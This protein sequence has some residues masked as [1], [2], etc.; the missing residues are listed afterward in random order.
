MWKRSDMQGLG[1]FLA[2]DLQIRLPHIGADEDDL[3]RQFVADDGG[4][5]PKGFGCSFAAH[6]KQ[7]RDVEI[8]LLNQ[9]QVLVAF[10]ILD[11]IDADR[12][13]LA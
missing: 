11:L 13:D 4:K 1:A 12:I 3:R 7:V 6:P 8:D 5:C 9:S 2:N 10:G